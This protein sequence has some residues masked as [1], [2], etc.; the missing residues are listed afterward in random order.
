M[1]PV[2]SYQIPPPI[3]PP[4]FFPVNQMP[5]PPFVPMFHLPLQQHLHPQHGRTNSAPETYDYQPRK[6]R[7]NRRR[8]HRY[9]TDSEESDD[10]HNIIV[11]RNKKKKKR[12]S[13]RRDDSDSQYETESDEEQP[14][15][16]HEVNRM[17]F[18]TAVPEYDQE[19]N[20]YQIPIPAKPASPRS[21]KPSA[22]TQRKSGRNTDRSEETAK[23]RE[24]QHKKQLEQQE[25]AVHLGERILSESIKHLVLEIVK[26]ESTSHAEIKEIQKRE[27]EHQLTEQLINDLSID[28]FNE[29]LTR[30]LRPMIIEVAREIIA[31][32]VN[33]ESLSKA[34]SSS[35]KLFG[36][37]KSAYEMVTSD[38][39]L[40]SLK[41][42]TKEIAKQCIHEMVAEYVVTEQI[43]DSVIRE[44]IMEFVQFE[45][46]VQDGQEV[47]RL[48]DIQ[49]DCVLESYMLEI[50]L[51]HYFVGKP[52]FDEMMF[53]EDCLYTLLDRYIFDRALR[54]YLECSQSKDYIDA[55]AQK[56]LGAL[57]SQVLREPPK[58]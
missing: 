11:I 36:D 1:A 14:R 42:F 20:G 28:L 44:F 57:L 3:I 53:R 29:F 33:M 38:V 32:H 37:E 50:C 17:S 15:Y 16:R 27:Q 26:E 2:P 25:M 23:L 41:D 4:P 43:L 5:P 45:L 19:R 6:K 55:I 49:L 7:R 12:R 13:K 9:E 10:D 30:E 54:Q 39:I 56:T 31:L 47:E 40:W 24:E 48:I 51:E 21:V 52:Y 34:N 18:S 22:R 35:F 58:R 46:L 8:S